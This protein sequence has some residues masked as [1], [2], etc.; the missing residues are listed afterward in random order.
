[1]PKPSCQ[2]T[3]SDTKKSRFLKI[4]CSEQEHRQIQERAAEARMTVSEYVRRATTSRQVVAKDATA[5]VSELR[6]IGALIK[7]H[8]P[9]V[10]DWP[11]ADKKRY[12]QTRD[13]FLAYASQI[14]SRLGI[15][16][17]TP[18]ESR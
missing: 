2:P 18:G 10:K 6:R 17:T 8:Y 9:K 4:R 11:D 16:R 12:W 15:K 13:Q 14:A 1:M 3:T 5:V 7:H